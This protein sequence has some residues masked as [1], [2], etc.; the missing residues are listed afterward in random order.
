MK[1]T[2]REDKG[3]S[4]KQKLLQLDPL[5]TALIV[6]S[7]VC[8]LLALQ[9]G[10]TKYEWSNSRVVAMLVVF[11]VLLTL[12]ILA[13]IFAKNKDN[14]TIPGHIIKNRSIIAAQLYV[15]CLNGSFNVVIFY[16][17][18]W[19]Q[20]IQGVDAIQSGIR[21]FPSILSMVLGLV[22]SG[23]LTGK[24]GYYTPLAYAASVIAPIG[25]GLMTLWTPNTSKGIWIGYQIVMGFGNGIGF[26]QA[27]MAAQTVLKRRDVP[28]GASIVQ[29]AQLLGGTVFIA[30]GQNLLTTT[31][32]S[33]LAPLVPG[34]NARDVGNL[35]AVQLRGLVGPEQLPVLLRIY[36]GAIR[37][38]FLMAAGLAAA[39]ALGA[40]GLEWK[41][42]KKAEQEHDEISTIQEKA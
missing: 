21:T 39:S 26:T 19:F 11:A 3:L 42:V 23:V 15:F 31:L 37:Q 35:G 30:V 29:F 8:L 1:R 28:T 20:V 33:G 5:G 36:N 9:W 10:G 24:I 25:I 18:L 22:V 2:P 16:L 17:P 7:L 27:N 13:Q 14:A 34:L 38:V 6:P 12:F 40:L 41:S 32:A 4:L